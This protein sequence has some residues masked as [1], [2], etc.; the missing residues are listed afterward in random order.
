MARVFF[1]ALF[2][3]FV[4]SGWTGPANA[5]PKTYLTP[6]GAARMM[7]AKGVKAQWDTAQKICTEDGLVVGTKP[8]K[9]CFAEYQVHSLRALRTRAKGLT[10]AVAKRHG[11]CI[12][13]H[14]FE[15]SRCKEI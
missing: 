9:R 7:A 14:R 8:F 13:R 12:D 15:I 11:L 10:D 5:N 1:V 6:E 4:F 2:A 3:A